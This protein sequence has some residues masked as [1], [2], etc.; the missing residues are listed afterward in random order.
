[1]RSTLLLWVEQGRIAPA[2]LV[3]A[4]ALAQV[5]PTHDQWRVFLDRLLLWLGMV[6]VAAGVIFFLAY[7][8]HELGRVAK[9]A[10]VQALLLA[11]L[12]A[13]VRLGLERAGGQAALFGASLLLGALLAL[14]GQTYQ[15]GADTFELFA[16]WAAM[17]LPWVL[18]ARLPALWLLWLAL[19]NLAIALYFQVFPS[20]FGLLFQTEQVLWILWAFNTA[21]L[22][23]WELLAE[24]GVTWLAP[25]WAPRVLASAS[26]GLITVL[27]MM[28]VLAWR[29]SHVW[30]VPAWLLWLAAAWVVYRHAVRDL[31]VLAGG[32][33]SVIVVASAFF[34]KHMPLHD[35][36]S[37]LL[38]GL[39]VIA[40]SA[41]GG[42]WLRQVA[43]EIEP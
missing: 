38:I 37:F 7:N 8:W 34:I 9:L 10:L 6:L 43:A 12:L 41:A 26:G 19:I 21:A 30:A 17:I 35:A 4:L 13:V 32:V 1:M 33:L 39:V 24:R 31:F 29:D 11:A 20:I 25:R 42:W 36:G 16:A 5:L 2:D 3:R 14:I 18:L 27:A 23:V 28:Q 22:A 15:T 40:L